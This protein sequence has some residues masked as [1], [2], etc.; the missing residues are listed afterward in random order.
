MSGP[1]RRAGPADLPAMLS[2]AAEAQSTFFSRLLERPEVIALVHE[3]EGKVDGFLLADLVPAPPVYDPGG[4][5]LRVDDFWVAGGADWKGAGRALLDAAMAEGHSRGAA[6]G[7]VVTGH[8]DQQK[9][10]MLHR[11]GFTIASKWWV[12]GILV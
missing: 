1:V 5:T 7:V 10:E 3:Q 12:R 2:L 9:R 6:Q 8:L 11:A 4:L